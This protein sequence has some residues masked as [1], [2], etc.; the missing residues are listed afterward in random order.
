[1]SLE[2]HQYWT[3]CGESNL[4]QPGTEI[5]ELVINLKIPKCLRLLRWHCDWVWQLESADSTSRLALSSPIHGNWC[6]DL[7]VHD[8]CALTIPCVDKIRN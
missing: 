3:V 5:Y 2:S 8:L 4:Q 6:A 7:S 1:M